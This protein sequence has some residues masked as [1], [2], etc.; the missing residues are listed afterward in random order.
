MRKVWS[1]WPRKKRKTQITKIRNQSGDIPN[2]LTEIKTIIRKY[3]KHFY[4]N[5]LDSLHEMDKFLQTH[6]TTKTGSGKIDNLNKL[7]K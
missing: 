1:D 7:S 5:K 3:Y 2:Y 4:A 6:K